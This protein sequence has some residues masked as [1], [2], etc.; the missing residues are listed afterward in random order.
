MDSEESTR[1]ED[2]IAPD[3][4]APIPL[5]GTPPAPTESNRPLPFPPRIHDLHVS[6]KPREKL[7]A[8]GPGA[9]TDAELLAIFF[10]TGTQ[11]A[12]AIE[13][14]RQ[15]LKHFDS[16]QAL[17]RA[18]PKEYQKIPGI[19]P[20]KAIELAA[21]FEMAKRVAKEEFQTQP[22][23]C[24][25][26][27]YAYLGAEMRALP[28]EV[29]RLLL[30]DTKGHLIRMEEVSSGSVNETVAHP[31][32]IL[33]P[34]VTYSAHAFILVHNHP[35]GD[36]SPSAADRQVTRRIAEAA[37]IFQIRFNDHIIIGHPQSGKTPYFSFRESGVL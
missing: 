25:E 14:A 29:V 32:E 6:E 33:R 17:S 26:D 36:P 37:N 5:P 8:K 30:L 31:R 12:N 9:L 23:N 7:A 27:V 16:L 1:A 4:T 34:A 11:G 22:L 3:Y 2:R 15:L 24:P 18:Q 28:R 13:I 20:V 35:S 19:G 10:R 21:L